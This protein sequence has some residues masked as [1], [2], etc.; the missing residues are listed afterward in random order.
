MSYFDKYLDQR[1]ESALNAIVARGEDNPKAA[2]DAID[3]L[4]R[5]YP[6]SPQ[7]QISKSIFLYAE[8]ASD[9]FPF[10]SKAIQLDPGFYDRHRRFSNGHLCECL[11]FEGVTDVRIKYM[12]ADLVSGGNPH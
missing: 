4:M 6:N 11:H 9:L 2:V 10:Y 7:L 12:H 8:R 3:A 1:G 5:R